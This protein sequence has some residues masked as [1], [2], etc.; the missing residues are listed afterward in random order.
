MYGY[1]ETL[2]S[3]QYGMFLARFSHYPSAPELEL[4]EEALKATEEARQSAELAAALQIEPTT[5]L[6]LSS[7]RPATPIAQAAPPKV[8]KASNGPKP[9]GKA[10][11]A[12]GHGTWLKPVTEA[13][14]LH[15]LSNSSVHITD[16]DETKHLKVDTLFG[17]SVYKCVICSYTTEQHAQAATHVGGMHLSTCLAC[18]LCGYRTYCLV[19]FTP[20]LE[21]KTP[22]T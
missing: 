6:G 2:E 19:D 14:P 11:K 20:H 8:A 1:L 17:K 21:K 4:P 12:S 7:K 15:P 18:R 5:V 13:I 3:R 9:K 22:P 16:I 10:A